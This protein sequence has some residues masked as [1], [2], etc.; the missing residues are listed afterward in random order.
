[1]K[2][3]EGKKSTARKIALEIFADAIDKMLDAQTMNYVK[4]GEVSY[5]EK[6]EEA[7]YEQLLRISKVK[8]RNTGWTNER[9]TL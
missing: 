6:E 7:I 5:T 4:H 1:M 8:L 9:I 2:D 3:R